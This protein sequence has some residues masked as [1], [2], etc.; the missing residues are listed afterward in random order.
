[1]AKRRDRS[2]SPPALHTVAATPGNAGILPATRAAKM[3]A[4][5]GVE[6]KE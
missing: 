3:A 2:E 1:M 5:P 4:V 6:D